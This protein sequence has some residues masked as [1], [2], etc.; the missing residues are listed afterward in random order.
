MTYLIGTRTL[1]VYQWTVIGS[2]KGRA[3]KYGYN[4]KT[5]IFSLGFLSYYLKSLNNTPGY[6]GSNIFIPWG[7]TFTESLSLYYYTGRVF[8]VYSVF[9]I[10]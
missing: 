7:L 5:H 1:P 8:S 3:Y 4:Y 9:S 6:P 2:D 10:Q